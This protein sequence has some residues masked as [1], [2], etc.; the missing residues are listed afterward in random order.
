MIFLFR[1]KNGGKYEGSWLFCK[2]N[3]KIAFCRVIISPAFECFN[4][5]TKDLSGRGSANWYTDVWLSF[6]TIKWYRYVFSHM[7]LQYEI[8][9]RVNE[10]YSINKIFKGTS[11]LNLQSIPTLREMIF[12]IFCTWLFHLRFSFIKTPRNLAFCCFSNGIPSNI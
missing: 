2:R 6:V 5:E 7:I 10:L 11:Y 3:M 9:G 8:Y 4:F 12:E 1:L